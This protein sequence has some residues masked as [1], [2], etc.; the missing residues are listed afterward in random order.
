MAASEAE[1]SGALSAN[2]VSVVRPYAVQTTSLEINDSAATGVII[3]IHKLL[4]LVGSRIF[5][6]RI[7]KFLFCREIA[8]ELLSWIN[9]REHGDGGA[10]SLST[11]VSWRDYAIAGCGDGVMAVLAS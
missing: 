8:P 9:G 3:F 2:S 1:A 7:Q 5:S 4:I 6:V 10:L 11:N